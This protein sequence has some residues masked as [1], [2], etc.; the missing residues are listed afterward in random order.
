LFVRELVRL[1]HADREL[2]GGR[3]GMAAVVPTGV[4]AVIGRR[5]G[6][7]STSVRGMLSAASVIG[8]EF[9]L[10]I[11]TAVTGQ[12]ASEVLSL[13]DEAE[14]ARLVE[15]AERRGSF[16]FVHALVREVVYDQLGGAERVELH[17]RVADVIA[18]R[19]GDTRVS[20]LAH[21]VLLGSL[22]NSDP[23]AVDLA[24]HAG[25]RSLGLLAYEEAGGWFRRALDVLRS[26]NPGD[27]RES[28][29]LVRC[30]AALS[31]AG[32]LPASRQ[33]NLEA[34]ALARGHED[35]EQLARAALGLGAGLGGFEV[36]LRDLVQVELLEEAARTLDPAP[37][38]LRAWVLARL[39]VALSFMDAEDRRRSLSEEAIVLAREVGDP[40]ALGYALAAHCDVI[41]G[42]DECE[43]RLA[44]SAE[45]TRLAQQIGNREL[46]LLGRRL[47]IVASLEVG[48]I[49]AVDAQLERYGQVAD[50]L[51]QPLYQWY[52]PLWRGMRALMRRELDDVARRCAEAEELGALAH[53][54]NAFAL[55]ITQSWVRQRYEGRFV[56]AGQ[57]M[58]ELLASA[59][60]LVPET[61][62]VRVVA[63]AQLGD[64]DKARVLLE[65]WMSAGLHERARDSEWLPES[66]QLA[67]V[68][69]IVGAREAAEV[70][71]DQLEPYH[72]R[73]CVEGIGAAFTGSVSWY[74][75]IV[76]RYLGRT[77]DAEAYEAHARTA[78]RSVGLVGDPP[79]LADSARVETSAT[80]P[81][82]S[83][84][85]ALLSE[86][87]TWA[88]TYGGKTR[89]L[90]DG[91]GVR[92]L[93]VLLAR[94]DDEV[95][96]L[97]LVGG[98]DVG[99]EAGPALDDQAR[100]VYQRR[101]RDLQ[102]DID[103]ARDANDPARAERAEAE[104]DILVQQLSGAFGLSGRA[105][106]T[107]SSTERARSTVSQRVR[108]A[109]RHIDDVHPEL[110]RHLRNSIRT[111]VWCSYRPESA[112]AWQ[113]AKADPPTA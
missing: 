10:S 21:H 52:V 82:G 83:G 59:P 51:R 8:T 14:E 108:A 102:E 46:E 17:H 96:C 13:V 49:G 54:D 85:A 16:S 77:A 19:Y 37:S 47:R 25:E 79:A 18:D 5:L 68:A 62:T 103:D 73:F 65:Q 23:R 31:A 56:E 107:G 36:R 92:D 39:S 99:S 64:H 87:A 111:G 76:A 66:A 29:L 104:L 72:R 26:E 88:V 20:E 11:L 3:A 71:F 69:V 53:S 2:D 109:L 86:G 1:L 112:V 57:G 9:E 44:E 41:A 89:R 84:G 91:K 55:T 97:E 42:P 40:A 101:I 105:R 12:D 113:I 27:A 45:V 110:G 80:A 81:E 6:A 15:P 60:D 63:A 43:T 58:A 98:V 61:A 24:V 4:R 33:A 32:D 90:R 93:A 70:L 22:D 67:E 106:A 94:P 48:D 38:S 75:A 100:R 30:G 34:A 28:D 74:L 35:P 7:L 50:R 78:H 95:H